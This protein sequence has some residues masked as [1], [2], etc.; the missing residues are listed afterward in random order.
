MAIR[1]IY[2]TPDPVLRQISKPVETFDDELK[3]LVADMF[4]TMYA[5]PGIGLAAVQV[6]EPIRLLVIDLQ[7]P[8]DPEDPESRSV[9]VPRVFINPE[10]LWHS[11]TEVPY[12]EGCLSI[13]EQYAE[14]LRPDRIRARWRDERGKTYEEEIEG[15]LAV[16][17]QHEMDHLNGVLFI[18]HL[19]RLKRDMILKKI[20]KA[21][22]EQLKA[23]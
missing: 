6:G 17:L 13:P 23:A 1:R 11:D 8:Q 5:A 2:E 15:L 21:R 9:K 10:V 16:C 14:V 12:T 19:S 18:D 3:T 22:K 7:E 20:A 4:E